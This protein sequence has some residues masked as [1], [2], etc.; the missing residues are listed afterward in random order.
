MRAAD[1]LKILQEL[2]QSDVTGDRLFQKFQSSV[3]DDRKLAC[4]LRGF[5]LGEDRDAY[6]RYLLAR[7]RQTVSALILSGNIAALEALDAYAVYTE[8]LTDEFL[9]TAIDCGRQEATVWLLKL[10]AARFGFRDKDFSL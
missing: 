1:V 3:R 9:K 6:L 2:Q 5:L 10:K 7:P 8:S 4:A